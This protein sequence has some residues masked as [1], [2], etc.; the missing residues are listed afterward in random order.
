MS[1]KVG[2]RTKEADRQDSLP[3]LMT[4]AKGEFADMDF[5]SDVAFS[6][7]IH[8]SKVL[9]EKYMLNKIE[10]S[11]YNY[12]TRVLREACEIMRAYK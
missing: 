1:R 12:N 3:A 11:T 7:L 6:M 9:T 4:T 2:F 10:T 8:S 5:A